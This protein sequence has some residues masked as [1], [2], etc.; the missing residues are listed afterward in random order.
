[1]RIEVDNFIEHN[2]NTL[3]GFFEVYFLDLG[4]SIPGFSLHE[5]KG[6]GSRWIELPA[7]PNKDGEYEKVVNAY[8]T[9]QVKKFKEQLL[10]LLDEH[11]RGENDKAEKNSNTDPDS[12]E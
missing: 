12:Q 3:Q 11:R 10:N 5:K 1:M 2:R 4:I 6:T 8:D 7:K 9:R